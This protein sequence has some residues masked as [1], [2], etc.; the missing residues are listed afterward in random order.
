MYRRLASDDPV[1]HDPDLA[2]ALRNHAVHLR[3][4]IGRAADALPT[5][6]ESIRIYRRLAK[7]NPVRYGPELGRA[8]RILDMLVAVS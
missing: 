4:L 6:E 2:L 3:R 7:N 5:I 8:L 1:R